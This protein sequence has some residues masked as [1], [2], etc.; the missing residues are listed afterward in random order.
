MARPLS[1]LFAHVNLVALPTIDNGTGLVTGSYLLRILF[2]QD[3]TTRPFKSQMG[4]A[5]VPT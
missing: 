2:A 1:L 5:S 4:N 3:G